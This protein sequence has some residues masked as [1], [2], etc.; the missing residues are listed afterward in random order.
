MCF[1]HMW[2]CRTCHALLCILTQQQGAATVRQFEGTGLTLIV[3]LWTLSCVVDQRRTCINCAKMALAWSEQAHAVIA[4][5]APVR[6]HRAM[7][8]L[9]AAFVMH[10]ARIVFE[11]TQL[12]RKVTLWHFHNASTTLVQLAMVLCITQHMISRT[13]C[14]LCS[15]A[16]TGRNQCTIKA[17]FA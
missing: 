11:G 4:A 13:W 15:V 14:C 7:P 10:C 12:V 3:S 2:C 16:K 9:R 17:H 1:A 5:S 6:A 8:I